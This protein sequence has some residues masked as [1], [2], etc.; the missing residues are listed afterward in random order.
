M[1]RSGP[2]QPAQQGI[3]SPL[4]RFPS[5]ENR[6]GR[7]PPTPPT[8]RL[9]PQEGFQNAPL[10]SPLRDPPP[11]PGRRVSKNIWRIN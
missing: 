9:P 6:G 4:F 11:G 8:S 5:G 10:K 2:N 1:I 7:V 3:R